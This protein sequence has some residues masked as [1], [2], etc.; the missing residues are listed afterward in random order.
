[1]CRNIHPLYNF[2]PP[3]TQAEIEAAARQFV[4]TVAG[5]RTPSKSNQAA[6]DRAALQVTAAVQEL[7]AS[8]TTSAPPRNREV[9]ASRARL[10]AAQ[11]FP[12]K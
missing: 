2:E 4:R 8:L 5:F 10:R 11:R 9:E 12:P 3:A 6:M 7:L 1:M